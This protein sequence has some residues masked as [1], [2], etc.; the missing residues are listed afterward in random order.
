MLEAMPVGYNVPT[1]RPGS[2]CVR[3]NGHE[4]TA[5]TNRIVARPV[6]IESP[7]S[8]KEIM[9]RVRYIC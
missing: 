6:Q 1:G 2:S 8:S 7:H 9:N 3:D 4:R 5:A